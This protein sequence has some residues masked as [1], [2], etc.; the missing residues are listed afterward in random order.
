MHNYKC[1]IQQTYWSCNKLDRITIEIR[2]NFIVLTAISILSIKEM[3]D[4]IIIAIYS[5][6]Y[7]QTALNIIFTFIK[8]FY[9]LFLKKKKIRSYSKLNRNVTNINQ[10]FVWKYPISINNLL[11][12]PFYCLNERQFSAD[13]YVINHNIAGKQFTLSCSFIKFVFNL[14]N[15]IEQKN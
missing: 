3:Y 4:G 11:K 8:Y 15:E 7:L 9:P 1:I 2:S 12:K 5:N 13:I 6:F 14:F 10:F